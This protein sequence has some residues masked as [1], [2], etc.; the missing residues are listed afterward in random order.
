[1][2]TPLVALA[3]SSL[4]EGYQWRIFAV[5]GLVVSLLGNLL[6]M[7]GKAAS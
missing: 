3:L 5:A 6:V 1:V 4:F 2:L 7:R